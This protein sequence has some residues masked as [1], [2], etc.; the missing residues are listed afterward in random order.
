MEKN[1]RNSNGRKEGYWE[2]YYP[3]TGNLF[4]RGTYIRKKVI[5][6]II[7]LMVN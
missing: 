5:G 1:Q 2:E 4:Y 7:I 6:N 3:K